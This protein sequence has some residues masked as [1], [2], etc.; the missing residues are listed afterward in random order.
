LARR[1]VDAGLE[2]HRTLGAGFIES[3]YEEALAIEFARRVIP[4]ERQVKL[5][6]TYKGHHVGEARMDLVVAGQLII[7]L[8]AVEAIAPVHVAQ[9]VSYLRASERSLALIFNFNVDLFRKG[10]RR[11]VLSKP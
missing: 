11:I 2:V 10:I 8:K 9:V 5:G 4:F 3:V 1:V 6:V 7:E